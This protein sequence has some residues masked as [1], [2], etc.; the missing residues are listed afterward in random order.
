MY[1]AFFRELHSLITKYTILSGIKQSDFA[2]EGAKSVRN[3]PKYLNL[4]KTGSI[5]FGPQHYII[6]TVANL[7]IYYYYYLLLLLYILV[8]ST[9]KIPSSYYIYSNSITFFVVSAVHFIYCS[10]YILFNVFILFKPGFVLFLVMGLRL[11]FYIY[12]LSYHRSLE[13]RN[14]ILCPSK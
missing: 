6:F 1:I 8:S 11:R 3:N 4:F 12:L 2:V 7:Y 10:P 13:S 5:V 14:L 9:Q